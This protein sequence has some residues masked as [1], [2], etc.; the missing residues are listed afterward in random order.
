MLLGKPL[1]DI[2]VFIGSVDSQIHEKLFKL[3]DTTCLGLGDL[4][5]IAVDAVSIGRLR[6]SKDETYRI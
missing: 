2:G 6:V 1:V 3:R 4:F 5:E